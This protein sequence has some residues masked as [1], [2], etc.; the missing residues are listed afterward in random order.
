MKT[1]MAATL[2]WGNNESR[3]GWWLTLPNNSLVVVYGP[4]MCETSGGGPKA[5][6][7]EAKHIWGGNIVVLPAPNHTKVGTNEICNCNK[8]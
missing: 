3:S 8:R 7:K 2:W 4:S 5:A 6:L 1:K